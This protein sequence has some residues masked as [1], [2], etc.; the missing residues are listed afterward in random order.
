MKE[1]LLQNLRVARAED[2]DELIRERLRKKW[3]G[4]RDLLGEVNEAMIQI[5]DEEKLENVWDLNCLVYSGALTAMGACDQQD[6][7][8]EKGDGESSGQADEVEDPEGEREIERAM[9]SE[10]N[11]QEADPKPT[12]KQQTISELRQGIGWIECEIKRRKSGSHRLTVKQG[13]RLKKLQVQLGNKL[14]LQKLR[15][16]LE[17]RKNLS[18]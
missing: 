18:E 7:M 14:V 4:P 8:T 5:W 13:M 10:K 17:K 9:R 16:A 15:S 11:P 2:P 1:T 12:T 3:N 6:G